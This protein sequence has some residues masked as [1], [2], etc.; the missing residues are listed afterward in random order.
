L[1]DDALL[2]TP[3]GHSIA[4]CFFSPAGPPRGAALIVP[5]MGVPQTFYAPL[6]EW[7]AAQG[8][9]VATFD[10]Q[11]IGRSLQGKLRDVKTTVL[12][13]ASTDCAAAL[14]A[15]AAR[16]PGLP[17]FWIGHSLGGQI[18]PFVPNAGRLTKVV[19][20]AAGSGYWRQNSPG[21]RWRVWWLWYIVVPIVVPLLG[22][23]PGRALRVIGDLPRGVMEQWR[24]WCLDREYAVGVEGET[25]RARYAAVRTP[26]LSLSFTDD[27]FMSERNIASLHG[28]YLHAPRTMSRLAPRD[29]GERRI[30]HFGFFRPR[31]E[32]S[33]WRAY[34]LPALA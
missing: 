34:L 10:Y 11:G 8:F 31:H 29:V 26:I 14:D 19:T 20:V 5:A 25:A 9:L 3:A 16:A 21:L 17:L 7:L 12:D 28:F 4:A 30:G 27:E 33:L 18:L 24:R 15:L 2:P 6:A 32:H 13:W 1:P 23:F 22:Y